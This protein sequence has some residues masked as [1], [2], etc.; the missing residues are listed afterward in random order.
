M[1]SG[2]PPFHDPRISTV[3]LYEKIVKGP[4]S[5]EWPVSLNTNVKNLVLKLIEP[6]PSKRLGNLA[7]ARGA[8]SDVL[9]HLWFAE[10][11]WKKLLRREM[12][13]P[14]V[15]NISH[16]GDASACVFLHLSD[17]DPVLTAVSAR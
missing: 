2:L 3:E 1:L 13:A 10:V 11:D 8:S 6:D 7:Q 17:S 15:P 12:P 4:A 9:A 14:Y 16:N 5:I